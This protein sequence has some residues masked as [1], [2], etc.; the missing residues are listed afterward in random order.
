MKT[1]KMITLKMF[2]ARV[3]AGGMLVSLMPFAWAASVISLGLWAYVL[4]VVSVAAHE[5]GAFRAAARLLG[6]PGVLGAA[7]HGGSVPL[8]P[9]DD[10]DGSGS[11]GG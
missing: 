11:D 8:L 4:T 2:N 9:A 3:C 10:G 1:L 6:L 7:P 5:R